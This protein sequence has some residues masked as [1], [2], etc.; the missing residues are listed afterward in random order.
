[1][2]QKSSN[3]Q[4]AHSRQAANGSQPRQRTLLS[5]REARLALLAALI[6]ITI[7][8]LIPGTEGRPTLIGWDKLDHVTSFAALALL[9]RA[10]WPMARR[11]PTAVALFGY[12][13]A[14]ELGQSTDFVG[15]TASFSDLA[16]NGVGIVLGLALAFWLARLARTMSWLPRRG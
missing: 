16:A 5:R 8:A 4:S 14:I 3:K 12:G 10:G 2:G 7:L 6:L 15:R 11:A 9:A 1:M 13:I